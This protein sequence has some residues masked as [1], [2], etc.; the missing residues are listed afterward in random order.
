MSFYEGQFPAPNEST[1]YH[2]ILKR[3]WETYGLGEICI[4][5]GEGM[6]SRD[7]FIKL[8]PN[9]KFI[10]VD[11]SAKVKPDF[12][13]D[14]CKE[15][16]IDLK[17]FRNKIGSV[18]CQAVIEHIVDPVNAIRNFSILLK[19]DGFIYLHGSGVKFPEHRYP[20]D[21]LRFLE[22]WFRMLPDYLPSIKL[23]DLKNDTN[24]NIFAVYQKI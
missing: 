14:I 12:I 15:I 2:G 23:I 8:F 6:E 22:D 17:K 3:W 24:E 21:C 20:C 7:F 9:V 19:S 10:T 1:G 11:V 18:L 16:P 13:W 5:V 4:I